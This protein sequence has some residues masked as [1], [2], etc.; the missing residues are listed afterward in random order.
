ME[1][2]IGGGNAGTRSGQE[3]QNTKI[4]PRT[5]VSLIKNK[6]MPHEHISDGAVA[7]ATATAT[8]VF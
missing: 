4:R 3:R 1:E 8:A 7:V 6:T 5:A 2:S